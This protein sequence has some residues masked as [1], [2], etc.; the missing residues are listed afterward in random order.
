[1]LNIFNNYWTV[2]LLGVEFNWTVT[3]IMHY[4]VFRF[5][6]LNRSWKEIEAVSSQFKETLRQNRIAWQG[7]DHARTNSFLSNNKFREST[8]SLFINRNS[9]WKNLLPF[10]RHY[11][12]KVSNDSSEWDSTIDTKILTCRGQ[13]T[14][15]VGRSNR[16]ELHNLKKEIRNEAKNL[17]PI[18]ICEIKKK[19]WP[20]LK[21]NK[22]VRLLVKQKQKYLALLSRECGLHSKRVETQVTSWLSNLD[23][24]IF[25]IETVYK[26]SGNKTLGIDGNKLNKENLLNYIDILNVNNLLE[27]KCS[28][29]RKVFIPKGKRTELRSFGIP[30][31]GDRIVQT[32]FVQV[33]EPIIDPHADVYSFGYRKGR[34][35]HQAIGELSKILQ[36]NP[37]LGRKSEARR[38][39][40][41]TKYILQVDIKGFYDNA[42]YKFLLENYPIPRKYK[43]IL[44]EWLAVNVYYQDQV[45]QVITGFLQGSVIRPSLTNFTLNGL[46][47]IIIPNQVTSFDKKKSKFLFRREE[48]YKLGQ[49]IVR[50]QLVNRIVRF[51]DD[52]IIVCNDKH[53][54]EKIKIR[55]Q[56]F[57]TQ[58]GLKINEE[59]SI[60]V[61]WMNRAKIN[62][63][64]FTFHYINT[65][66]LSRIT[67]QRIKTEPIMRS[68]LYV[69]PSDNSVM[70][71]K[72]KISNLLTNLNWSPYRMIETL[73]PIIRRWGNY[74]CIGTSRQFSRIDHYIYYRTWRYL[75]RKFKKVPVKILVDRFYQRVA[76][77]TN[78]LWQFHDTWNK[79]PKNL[80]I[81]KGKIS[82]LLILCKLIK[83]MP[84]HMFRAENEVLKTSI[85]INPNPY[86]E[87][88]TWIFEKRN[89][90]KISNKWSELYK[91]QK[92]ICV[93]CGQSL[94]YLLEENL[95]IHHIKQVSK[96]G[97]ENQVN[98]LSNLVLI[99]KNCRKAIPVVK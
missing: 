54:V 49:S 23:M 25:A 12:Y 71:F 52:F 69:Y 55:L 29:I 58:R 63:L 72:K 92:G 32:L 60:C 35:A 95:E 51:A 8:S 34:S 24:R 53:E 61:K 4:L 59:K 3:R 45:D 67:E 97:P 41:H 9:W 77:P 20:M 16:R 87:W 5:D 56:K 36:T 28:G 42:N 76:T 18:L 31:V 27:Y 47:E 37:Y 64:G 91:R 10:V 81:R 75:R 73:N 19:V 89:V 40:S 85:Y 38:Y 14:G 6:Y 26:S 98:R 86:D 7:T 83:P 94:G 79:S 48:K 11:S 30:T 1:M 65:P 82:W 22:R 50:K 84:A 88:V 43:G 46:E 93:E 13:E 96:S 66:K 21:Y 70:K 2:K 62:Y 39:F 15:T 17:I 57:L 68:G 33:I 74:F 78:R 99:H 44:K 80:K 90:R